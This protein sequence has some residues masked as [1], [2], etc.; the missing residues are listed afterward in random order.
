MTTTCPGWGILG[1]GRIAD[2]FARDLATGGHR[3]VAVGSRNG[4]RAAAFAAEHGIPNVHASYEALVADPDVDVIYIATP[5]S[6][7][8]EH[9]LLAIEGGKHLL[10]EKAITTTGDDAQA[11][12]DAARAKGVFVM[13]A[14]WTRFL[15][16]MVAVRERIAA[17]DLGDVVAVNADHSQML[18]LSPGSRLIEP[19]LGGGALLDLGVYCVSLAHAVLGPVTRIQASG[20]VD[21]AGVDHRGAAI[22]EH[23]GGG[24][25]TVTF[26]METLGSNRATISGTDGVIELDPAFYTWTRYARRHASDH[27][28]IAEAFEPDMLG[29]GMQFQAA[30]VELC[31]ASGKLESE[32]MPLDESVAIMRVMDEILRQMR[33]LEL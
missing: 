10:I 6:H 31:I 25:S 5:H 13:E 11:I 8:R 27:A 16:T 26:S 12:V 28:A 29:R 15:P 30:E 2:A 18:D 32:L 3:L 24:I 9:A 1:P 22:L 21:A 20:V 14:M 7:H 17:G 33:A 19:S 4:E 23:A